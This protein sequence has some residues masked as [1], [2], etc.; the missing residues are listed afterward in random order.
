MSKDKDK[1]KL[2]EL[3][4]KIS[5]LSL[6]MANSES[7]MKRGMYACL[8]SYVTKSNA[9]MKSLGSYIN[10]KGKGSGF[11][12]F[13]W[14]KKF[15]RIFGLDKFN[16]NKVTDMSEA[17]VVSGTVDNSIKE[18]CVSSSQEESVHSKMR[19]AGYKSL[20]ENGS[21]EN[22]FEKD[23]SSDIEQNQ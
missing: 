11:F 21:V 15:K 10:P 19:K 14:F 8:E 22:K 20:V 1:D 5:S 4:E 6:E 7:A 16:K 2:V 13:R 23:K 17:A 9:N 12:V 18:S 3:S